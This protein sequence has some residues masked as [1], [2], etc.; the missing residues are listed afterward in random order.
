MS[1]FPRNLTI[2]AIYEFILNIHFPYCFNASRFAMT[3]ALL[4][5]TQRI[6]TFPCFEKVG[7][8]CYNFA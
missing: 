7:M 6:N 5:T 2:I 8:G 3:L 1:G 4:R